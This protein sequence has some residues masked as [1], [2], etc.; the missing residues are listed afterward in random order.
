MYPGSLLYNLVPIFITLLLYKSVLYEWMWISIFLR[1]LWAWIFEFRSPNWGLC[2]LE[3][4]AVSLGQL[5]LS[6]WSYH[7]SLKCQK[8][9]TWQYSVKSQNTWNLIFVYMWGYGVE[10]YLCVG[11]NSHRILKHYVKKF[12]IILTHYVMLA[13]ELQIL[14]SAV[15]GLQI[16]V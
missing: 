10:N 9:L 13:R 3:C 14:K 16:I 8:P 15:S 4:D 6:F 11:D 5:F 7:S 1:V 2:F 12:F